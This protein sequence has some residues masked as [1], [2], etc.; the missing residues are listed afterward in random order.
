MTSALLVVLFLFLL[1][2]SSMGISDAT[3]PYCICGQLSTAHR[4]FCFTHIL[5]CL[6]SRQSM[7]LLLFFYVFFFFFFFFFCIFIFAA[8]TGRDV[9]SKE[10]PI[11]ISTD[12]RRGH[13]FS[14]KGWCNLSKGIC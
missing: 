14:N 3:C 12:T 11:I 7:L 6:F 8:Q 10:K 1:L 4:L 13:F 2:L 9:E 5:I